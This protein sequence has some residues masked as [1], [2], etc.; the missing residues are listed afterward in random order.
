MVSRW[1]EA[2]TNKK[3]F[4]LHSEFRRTRQTLITIEHSINEKNEEITEIHNAYHEKTM[5]LEKKISNHRLMALPTVSLMRIETLSHTIGQ[6]G[7]NK[8]TRFFCQ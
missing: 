7:K 4:N 1:T 8:L 5:E 2:E 3:Y 6:I